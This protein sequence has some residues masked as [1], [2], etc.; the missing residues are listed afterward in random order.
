MYGN[1]VSKFKF[2][3]LGKIR[4]YPQFSFWILIAL[5]KIC[6]FQIVINRA[7]NTVVSGGKFLKKPEYLEMRRTYAQ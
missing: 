2:N 3:Y 1:L 7:K 5:S 6:F 4:G